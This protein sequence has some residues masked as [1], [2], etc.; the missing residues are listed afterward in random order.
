MSAS[1]KLKALGALAAT[2]IPNQ[3]ME[4]EPYPAVEGD[5]AWALLDALPQLVTLVEAAEGLEG[6]LPLGQDCHDMLYCV[7]FR[8]ALIAL[9]EALAELEAR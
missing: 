5:V 7:E 8:H 6:E 3:N 1:E 2:A 4:F 9:D